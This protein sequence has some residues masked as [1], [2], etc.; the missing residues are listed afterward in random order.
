MK[1]SRCITNQA[2]KFLVVDPSGDKHYLTALNNEIS[3]IVEGMTSH[4]TQQKIPNAPA[5]KFFVD[6]N[7]VKAVTSLLN[8]YPP[9]YYCISAV[10]LIMIIPV[11]L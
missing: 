11:Q 3:A 9:D 7:I 1:I 5:M 10:I 8:S 6:K 4:S 2:A